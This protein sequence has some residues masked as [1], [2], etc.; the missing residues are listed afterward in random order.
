LQTDYLVPHWLTE[1]LAVRIEGGDRPAAWMA[2]LRE[3]HAAGQL[4]DL[5]TI[6]L[7]F[8]RPRSE[9][10]WP[11]AYLQALLYVEYTTKAHGE[12]A[13]GKLLDAYRT[14]GSTAAVLKAAL[15]VEKAD[16]ERGYRRYVDDVVKGA[17][18]R[19]RADKPMT[20][21]ELEA[22]FKKSPDD[23][24]LMAR[25]AG[26]YL[27]RNKPADAKKLADAAL[28]KEKGHPQASVVKA[29][30]L[31]RD[32]DEAAARAVLEE[33]A[34]EN[35]EDTRV[36]LALGR[37]YI[38]AKEL[39]KAAA[40]FEKGRT[41]APLEADWLT[42][43]TRIYNTLGKTDELRSVL[44]ELAAR[45][46]DE[47]PARVKLAKL[48]LDAGKPAGAE[49]AAREALHV[50]V[51]HPAARDALLAALKAQKKDAEAEKIEKRFAD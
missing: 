31:A 21:P 41:A 28:A 7:A 47:V 46:P 44:A 49:K 19:R 39:E 30:L 17:G 38:E 12:A 20:F 43:L 35:P 4:L 51:T 15:G 42:E 32:K 50:D 26:E 2:V 16:F 22:A 24:D 33:A 34:K 10:D 37:A 23:P 40:A 45:D 3:R 13:V 11:L 29:R 14:G 1:G 27:R 8:V 48:L 6:T 9:D 36:L 18:P 5:D 25:L